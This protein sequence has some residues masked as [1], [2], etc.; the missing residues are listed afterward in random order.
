MSRKKPIEGRV[1][2][3]MAALKESLKH[4]RPAPAP[5]TAEKEGGD[6]QRPGSEAEL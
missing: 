5:K 2:D 6:H 4:Q 3:L 1:F